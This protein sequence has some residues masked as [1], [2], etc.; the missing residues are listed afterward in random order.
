M[1]VYN[2][3]I[4]VNLSIHDEWLKWMKSKH[5]PDVMHTGLFLDHKIF[6]ILEED[7][8]EGISY[9]IQYIAANMGDYLEY[10]RAHAPELQ[11][12]HTEKYKDQFVAFRTLLKSVE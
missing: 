8:R 5:I 4:K 7:E 9:A 3:T 12:E 11:K 6:R 2:V 10:Q 1:L